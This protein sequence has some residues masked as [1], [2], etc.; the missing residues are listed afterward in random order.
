MQTVDPPQSPIRS[1]KAFGVQYFMIVVSILTALGFEQVVTNVRRTSGAEDAQREIEEELRKNLK[2]VRES[3]QSNAGRLTDLEAWDGEAIREFGSATPNP[4]NQQ[5]LIAS[6]QGLWKRN[7]IWTP[8]LQHA[9]W[10][11]A[12]ANQSAGHIPTPTLRKYATAYTA[13][14]DSEEFTRLNFLTTLDEGHLINV[15]ADAD[16]GKAT[17]Q[18]VLRATRQLILVLKQTQNHLRHLEQELVP[19]LPGES[20]TLRN[21]APPASTAAAR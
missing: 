20:A 1:W 3:Y 13:Q 21:P 6:A 10:D 8:T 19:A 14:H 15:M 17:G 11:V 12:I 2:D 5:R 4:A 9:A 18:D 7:S 16:L